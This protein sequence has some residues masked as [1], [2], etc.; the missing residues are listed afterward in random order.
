MI[1]ALDNGSLARPR[2]VA[3]DRIKTRIA[4]KAWVFSN[5]LAV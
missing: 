5:R 3:D 1:S 4:R 2:A